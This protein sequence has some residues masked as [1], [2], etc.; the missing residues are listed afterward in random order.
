MASRAR[1][2]RKSAQA[3][4]PAAVRL[5]A[6]VAA[7][8]PA[9]P[10]P[11]TSFG[12]RP[13]FEEL[14]SR[15]LM[16]AD[17]NPLAHDTLLAG[18]APG[19]AEFR[20]LTDIGQPTVITTGAVA[21]I[22]RS[23]EIAFVDTATPDYERLIATMRQS[24]A[25][26]GRNLEIVLIE[27]QSD[28]IRAITE[29]LTGR[30]DL[31]AVHVVSHAADGTVQLGA[32]RLDFVTLAAHASSIK[33]WG[34]ALTENADILFYGCDLAATAKGKSLLDAVAR[35]TGADVAAS[36]DLTGS[37][38]RGGDWDLEFRSGTVDTDLLVSEEVADIWDGVLATFTVRNTNDSGSDSLREAITNANGSAGAD[39]IVFD[40]SS[41]PTGPTD[42]KTI[43][44]SSP[45]VITDRVT[46]DG[47]T[48]RGYDGTM[49]LIE[50]TRGGAAPN[51][52]ILN[53]GSGGSVV[54]GLII[55]RFSQSG[56][57][58]NAGSDGNTILGS[59][60]GI[61][62]NGNSGGGTGNANGIV[63]HSD[64]NT[65]GGLAP[66][67]RNVI[68]GASVDEVRI[69]SQ[70][71]GNQILGNFIGTNS[72]GTAG[73]ATAGISG[74]NLLGGGN[75]V[76][77][78][79]PEARNVISGNQ[80]GVLIASA[81]NVV[82]GNYLGTDVS[83]TL[84]RGNATDGIHL[85][86]GANANLISGNLISGNDSDGIEIAGTATGN[87][88]RGNLIGTNAAGGAALANTFMGVRLTG[89]ANGNIIGGIGAGDRNVIS[90]NGEDGIFVDG[91]TGTVIQGNYIG[92]S[93]AGVALAGNGNRGA[94]V[95]L[96]NASGTTI[97]GTNSNERNV[98]SGNGND[99]P[100]F[101]QGILVQ[102]SDGNFIL[103][104]YL[105]TNATGTG[106]VGNFGAGIEL[107][108]G[109]QDNLVAGNLISGNGADGVV[110]WQATA[111]VIR[112]NLIGTNAAG[113]AALGNGD[114]G[115]WITNASGNTIGGTS[116]T[117]GNVI[118]A[119]GFDGIAISAGSNDNLVQGNR[120][121]TNAAG[122]AAIPNTLAG[123]WINN[124]SR[125]T[126]GGTAANAGNLIS[127]NATSGIEIEGTSAQN[128]I[129]GNSIH[130]NSGG[131]GIDLGIVADG[132][133]TNDAGD[134]D[135]GPNALQN[136]PVLTSAVTNGSQIQLKGSL[137]STPGENF[138][139]EFFASS[140][141]DG[142]GHGEGQRF[143]G[144]IDVNTGGGIVNFTTPIFTAAVLPG[145][146]IAATATR[147]EPG[148][149]QF[150]ET[151]EF[152][153][154]FVAIPAYE[155][156]GTVFDDVD[157]DADVAEA[158]T[159]FF[160][161][162]TV[163]LFRDDGASVGFIDAGDTL[164]TNTTTNAAG[165]YAFTGLFDGT[166]YVV[167]DSKTLNPSTAAWA[168]Q[169]YGV[170][171][172]ATGGTFTATAGALYSGRTPNLSDDAS[173][174]T[175]TTA[176]HVTKVTV[177]A[178]NVNGIDSG[179]S[180]NVVTNVRGDA[181][182]DDATRPG[183]Q[184]QGTLRQF[185]ENAN[186]TVG[187]PSAMRF[188]PVVGPNAGG[189]TWWQ[190]N[191]AGAPLP[192]ILDPF[193]TIDGT[194]FA[195]AANGPVVDINNAAAVFTTVG[196][197]A[198]T[199]PTLAPPELEIT[200]AGGFPVGLNVGA[201]N[202]TIRDLAIF[203][204]GGGSTHTGDIAVQNAQFTLIEGNVIGAHANFSDPGALARGTRQ[205]ITVDGGDNGTIR[206]NL[207]GYTGYAGVDLFNAA[208]GW[209]VEYNEIRG[210]GWVD[211]VWDG[212]NL[213][214]VNGAF[215]QR[216]LITNNAGPGI[217][218][219]SGSNNVTID[220]NTI[221]NNALLGGTE[222]YGIDLEGTFGASVVRR[223]IISGNA[224]AGVL[225]GLAASVHI[226]ENSISNN[227]E[228]GIDLSATSG[229]GDGVTTNDPGDA[230]AGPN[231]LQNFPVLAGAATNGA[232]VVIN[233][234]L[235]STPLTTHRVEFFASAPAD[236]EGQRF[237]GIAMV[238]TDASGNGSFLVA[239]PQTV[240]LGEAVTATATSLASNETSEFSQA[241]FASAPRAIFR[242]DLRGPR[243]RCWPRRRG[244]AQRRHRPAVPRRRRRGRRRRGRRH[245][246]RH[247]HDRR[248][249]KLHFQRPGRR[250]LLG[251]GRFAHCHSPSRRP[252]RR[253]W[254]TGRHLGRPD[255]R[256][257]RC[258]R[259]RRAARG[260]RRRLRRPARIRLRRPGRAR[261]RPARHRCDRR[262]CGRH[263]RRLGVQLQRRH[264]RPRRH[265]RSRSRGRSAAAG[266]A[267][268]V[269]PQRQRNRRSAIHQLCHRTGGVAAYDRHHR[270]GAAGYHRQGHARRL[271]TGFPRIRRSAA[272]RA[273]R[274]GCG[275][276][277][278]RVPDRPWLERLDRARVRDQPV[279]RG[280]RAH[281]RRQHDHR[282]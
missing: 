160:G 202:T 127:G 179:F 170:V 120:I 45:L 199:L 159:A 111:N 51:A 115:I 21:P 189:G 147:S 137:T 229:I 38:R 80:A 207:I 121:G 134:G 223:N 239:L 167:V 14:E 198:W 161:G 11:P 32:A 224:G 188:V 77:G 225:V 16:S 112:S 63:I 31:T 1:R 49:P 64:N 154:N 2:T 99:A 75:T 83:G 227:A 260:R 186:A 34:N 60:I 7:P 258:D 244:R 249:R 89:T 149:T 252:L 26:Q 50:L 23:H 19:G 108:T 29:A 220:N 150:F 162:A 152:G 79:A 69:E 110:L 194:A 205:A 52:L 212:V 211:P 235:N 253:R 232:T 255:L 279:R 66:A 113:T 256:G 90:G 204:F 42:V 65:I 12:R 166:Y 257:R 4:K 196:V 274:R 102:S 175:L 209:M 164:L 153:P 116:G 185:I 270:R 276:Q 151:S 216:N 272:D 125:N 132:V 275:C 18:P 106:A 61:D 206:G 193:T 41:G 177:A 222:R 24:A 248:L 126:I 67:A 71:S 197:D 140:V 187:T 246:D 208:N 240:L 47:F 138:R 15:L 148:F 259:Q 88:V 273:E 236:P 215:I 269:H 144:S 210:V 124:S 78:T 155:I 169:T 133:T 234:T 231:A 135:T 119:S 195:A 54:T 104:N 72:T 182:D 264:Q 101:W 117:D 280:R 128:A 200:D 218:V 107:N 6:R 93:A 53:A 57:L 17:L 213:L 22:Q 172:A 250:R 176:E 62:S 265:R 5:R 139:I 70:G 142:S 180:L 268:P 278:G 245:F 43:S 103:G 143:L 243:R 251:R 58:I 171:G 123:I 3:A 157:G 201:S 277:C 55:N 27:S 242:H 261:E 10:A 262:R 192:T 82:Q 94:G 130:A 8:T 247:D 281:R 85:S 241:V 163:R 266:F 97:G 214:G 114:F 165:Q 100:D 84:D 267:P 178:I 203:G 30:G 86:S 271:D 158:G 28:G 81:D 98:I 156:R 131:L 181:N 173:T 168:E 39:T 109:S 136:F 96:R 76:G 129:L 105:G 36:E 35:L 226:T 46:I 73:V 219:A 91:V 184:Q 44:L 40:I 141:P 92:V 254:G 190:V 59:W 56:I 237:L 68:S 146:F 191:V 145:E 37:A 282:R 233:G 263:G 230:D 217:D 13:V 87:T 33:G 183:V 228:L 221:S 238:S 122:T 95:W 25:A 48:Q 20:S 174:L 9:R 118:S 74:V